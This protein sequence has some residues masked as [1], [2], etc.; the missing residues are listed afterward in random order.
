[1]TICSKT[2]WN[3]ASEPY[4]NTQKIYCNLSKCSSAVFALSTAEIV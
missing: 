1:M 3:E 2:K 4:N